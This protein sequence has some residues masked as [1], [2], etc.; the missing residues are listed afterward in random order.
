MNGSIIS[1][2]SYRYFTFGDPQKAEHIVYVLHGYGQLAEFFIR[3]FQTLPEKYFIVAPEGMHRFYISGSSGR[4]GASWMTKEDRESDIHDTIN[5]LEILDKEIN[6]NYSFKKK[7]LVGFSQGGATAA[8]WQSKGEISA[9]QM[10]IWASVYPPDL[11]MEEE[12]KTNTKNQSKNYFVIG[13][14]DEF[15][16]VEQQQELVNFYKSKGFDSA[17]YKGKHDVDSTVLLPLLEQL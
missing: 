13:N 9:D 8:R 17:I 7:S 12:I 10:I 11:L 15:Y 1:T 5:W 4:V 2:K 14:E 16:S 3:K 6:T